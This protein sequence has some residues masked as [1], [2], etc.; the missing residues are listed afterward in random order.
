MRRLCKSEEGTRSPPCLSSPRTDHARDRQHN[1]IPSSG[2]RNFRGR[3]PSCTHDKRRNM[4]LIT[5]YPSFRPLTILTC[6]QPSH[7]AFLHDQASIM[8]PRAF[9]YTPSHPCAR[10]H[11][12]TPSETTYT[13]ANRH[14]LTFTSAIHAMDAGRD[15]V[16]S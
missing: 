16:A 9:P 12:Q 5:Q 15:H 10:A 4:A 8:P 1:E 14:W 3:S 2:K 6:S 13:D 7:S 11:I